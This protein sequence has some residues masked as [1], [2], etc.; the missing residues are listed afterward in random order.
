MTSDD[1]SLGIQIYG[2]LHFLFNIYLTIQN[3]KY[4]KFMY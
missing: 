4:L 2:Q 3:N 1:K